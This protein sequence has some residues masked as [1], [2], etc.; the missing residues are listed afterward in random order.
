MQLPPPPRIRLSAASVF[1]TGI[2]LEAGKVV[3]GRTR[4]RLF[5]VRANFQIVPADARRLITSL[6]VA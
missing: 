5:L 2:V 1:E 3:N 4:I 6:A